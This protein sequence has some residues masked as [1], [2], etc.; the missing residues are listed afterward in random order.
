MARTLRILAACFALFWGG[1]TQAHAEPVSTFF[2]AVGS[3]VTF[4]AASG[5]TAAWIGA[6]TV[7]AV[8]GG[9]ALTMMITRPAIGQ[10][11]QTVP[12]VGADEPIG[13]VIGETIVPGH[14]VHRHSSG[15][16][17]EWF[18]ESRALCMGPIEE[19]VEIRINDYALTFSSMT[20]SEDG[21]APS[22]LSEATLKANGLPKDLSEAIFFT[23]GL[24]GT[25]EP[26]DPMLLEWGNGDAN[27]RHQPFA[28]IN[29]R[30][31]FEKFE[32]RMPKITVKLKGEKVYDPREVSHD[33]DDA[34]TWEW[35]DNT[36]LIRAWYVRQ[37][38][39]FAAYA[40]EVDY[41]TVT[42]AANIDDEL[43]LKQNGVTYEKRYRCG[44]LLKESDDRNS[45]LA[46]LT[47]ACGGWY[48]EPKPTGKWQF[49]S[50]AYMSPVMD[51]TGDDDVHDI[52][53]G[54]YSPASRGARNRYTRI[55][56][57]FQDPAASYKANGYP[58]VLITQ[59]LAREHKGFADWLAANPS[60]T[61]SQ[62][63]TQAESYRDLSLSLDFTFIQSPDQAQRVA[64]IRGMEAYYQKQWKGELGGIGLVVPAGQN[65]RLTDIRYSIEDLP[66]RVDLVRHEDQ[67][68][69]VTLSETN[70]AIY[71]GPTIRES[72]APVRPVLPRP[73]NPDYRD[74]PDGGGTL[75]LDEAV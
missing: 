24:G 22:E 70:S 72:T 56:G 33:E 11:G 48:V 64:H 43:V 6:L 40:E 47:N 14:A 69:I 20:N 35:S 57:S 28:Y 10:Q 61:Q 71:A 73:G 54:D 51:I 1:T 4:G 5:A 46:E 32:G 68:T 75:T 36:A 31:N 34:S 23:V 12:S 45:A 63:R 66:M 74:T 42:A 44:G 19:I 39:T 55:F 50:G 8:V 21:F 60:A 38:W 59:A 2:I 9:L 41:D 53:S 29:F 30:V 67:S 18:F 62:I 52:G 26:V 17:N 16:D 25:S 65:V 49:F 13:H 58:D 3:A 7:G 15:D 27:S 37:P